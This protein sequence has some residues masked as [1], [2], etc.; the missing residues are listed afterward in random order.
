LAMI[1]DPN[2][3][4]DRFCRNWDGIAPYARATIVRTEGAT[5]AK[6]GAK[7]I[8]TAQGELIGWLGGGCLKGAVLRAARQAIEA[9]APKLIRVRPKDRIATALDLDGVELHASS[10]PSKGSSDVF[11][12]PVLPKPLLAVIGASF[13][14]QSLA[15]MAEPLGFELLRALAGP[16]NNSALQADE[17]LRRPGIAH[18]Y[19]AV[20]TQGS[21]DHTA[22]TAAL[23]TGAPYVAFVSSP[24]KA[25]AMRERLLKEGVSEDRL[26]C[27]RAPAGLDIGSETPAEI[28]LAILAE[29]VSLRRANR[30]RPMA[31][32][33]PK[34]ASAEDAHGIKKAI[35]GRLGGPAIS[36]TGSPLAED[37][38]GCSPMLTGV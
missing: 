38:S 19:I 3:S 20:A 28:A 33:S 13:V 32:C 4:V 36:R 18:A 8:V 27:L 12:E 29:I 5:A 17:L 10:C 11:I 31:V 37:I 21:G 34:D 1:I 2:E 9:G 30:Y 26:A 15:A 24:A 23:A 14:A 16:G 6:A 7:A 25:L 22:L 35:G